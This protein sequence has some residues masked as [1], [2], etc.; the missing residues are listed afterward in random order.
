MNNLKKVLLLNV[1]ILSPIL[2]L[3][4]AFIFSQTNRVELV[5]LGDSFHFLF[6][7]LVI[8]PMNIILSLVSYFSLLKIKNRIAGF[9]LFQLLAVL[10]IIL[11][12]TF[13]VEFHLL[14]FIWIYLCF[15]GLLVLSIAFHNKQTS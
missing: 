10:F 1:V 2:A 5:D 3:V 15:N 8:T 12:T 4:T 11:L 7:F 13:G 6:M 9:L 14:A